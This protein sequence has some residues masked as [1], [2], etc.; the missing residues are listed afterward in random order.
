MESGA[1]HD[2]E[3]GL[4]GDGAT[5]GVLPHPHPGYLPLTEESPESP[6]TEI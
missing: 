5:H 3:E 6:S 2:L 1:G 4:S